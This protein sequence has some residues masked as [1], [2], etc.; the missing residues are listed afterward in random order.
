MPADATAASLDPGLAFWDMVVHGE[1]RRSGHPCPVKEVPR[2]GRIVVGVDASPHARRALAWAAA[3]ARLRQAVLQVVH[4]YHARNLAAPV[5]FGS[6]HTWD[7]TVGA[8]GAPSPPELSASVHSREAFEEAVRSQADEL[9]EALLGDLG[10]TMS[11]VEVQQTV[12]EDR[13]PA[14]ALV[15]LSADA[16]LLVVG[17]RGRGGF[18]E[19]LLGS[20]SHA[21]VLHAVCPVVV[22]P[23]SRDER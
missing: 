22:V 12:I 14:E 17:S 4:A 9:L 10:E 18:S 23:S 19:L 5:Y 16:D 20:V 8:A 3:E 7:A 21:A 6:Q 1:P 13:H 11:G 2:V 15:R